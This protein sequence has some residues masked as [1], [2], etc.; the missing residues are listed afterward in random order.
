[1]EIF[2]YIK[3]RPNTAIMKL[4]DPI[5]NYMITNLISFSPETDIYTV[6]ETFTENRI[7]GAPVLN[8]NSELVGIISEKDCIRSIMTRGYYNRIGISGSVASFMTKAVKTLNA[9]DS[10]RDAAFEFIHSHY[11]R[12]PVV[13]D[14]KLVGQVSRRDILIAIQEL[15]EDIEIIPSSW[16]GKVPQP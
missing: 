1:M 11:R 14:G 9:S 15:E 2:A 6:I 5:S 13:K 3:R 12:F 16:E 10:V 8:E 4:T 7:S